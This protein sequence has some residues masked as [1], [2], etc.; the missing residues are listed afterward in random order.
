MMLHMTASTILFRTFKRF[1]LSRP[2]LLSVTCQIN[3]DHLIII[4][5]LGLII[6]VKKREMSSIELEIDIDLINLI[7]RRKS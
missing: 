1:L 7:E 6:L 2:Y 4:K 3:K 5:I